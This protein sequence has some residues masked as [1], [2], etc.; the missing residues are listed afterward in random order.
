M[1]GQIVQDVKDDVSHELRRPFWHDPPMAVWGREQ[2]FNEAFVARVKRLRV[3]RG[4]TAER[5]AVNLG[6]PPERYRKY[7]SRTPLPHYLVA[8]FADLVERDVQ[9]LLTGK[10]FET[11]RR[12]SPARRT[13]ARG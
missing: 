7:E 4:W 3:E 2:E 11:S 8:P 9:Y 10:P 6:V 13:G 1:I 5:M 12:P